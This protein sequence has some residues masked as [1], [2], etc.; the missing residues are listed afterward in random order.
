MAKYP[1]L[2]ACWRRRVPLEVVSTYVPVSSV[3]AEQPTASRRSAIDL[4]VAG[5]RT[6][7]AGRTEHLPRIAGLAVLQEPG[8]AS[9]DR[10]LER[11]GLADD[12]FAQGIFARAGVKHRNLNLG[13]EFL[14]SSLQGRTE[15]VEQD[16]LRQAVTAVDRLEIARG[17]I[18]TVLSSSLCSLGCPSLAHRLIEHYGLDPSVDKY[19]LTAVGCASAVPLM[20]LGTQVLRADPSR[21]VLVV[22]AE[23]MSAILTPSR[24]GDPRVKTIGSAIFGDGCAAALLSSDR[25]ASGPAIVAVRVHQVPGTLDAVKLTVD[26][27]DSHLDL[28]R[29]LP[30]VAAA[31]LPDLVD[32]FLE[33]NGLTHQA[34]DRWMLHP[35]GRRVVEEARDALRLRDEDVEVSWRAL[36]GHG[37]VGTPS[38][39]YVLQ[40]TIDR[41]RPEPGDLGLAVTIGPGVTIGLMLLAF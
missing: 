7:D 19:H 29:E 37:N 17:K 11:L 13:D 25:D 39:F 35:G 36:A 26:D 34:I 10:A 32:R 6:R 12:E 1:P 9:Q 18:G 31:E 24:P 16:L 14:A 4:P 30:A 23:S 38:I 3:P 15:Q 28:A 8:Q 20:K 5:R 33:E 2:E 27:R 21:H 22:A 40:D 41:R